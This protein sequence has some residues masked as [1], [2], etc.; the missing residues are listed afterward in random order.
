M[1]ARELQI[2]PAMINNHEK[3]GVNTILIRSR[4]AA[5]P[6]RNSRVFFRHNNYEIPRALVH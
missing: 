6:I 1:R 2:C 3:K 5:Y 4:V